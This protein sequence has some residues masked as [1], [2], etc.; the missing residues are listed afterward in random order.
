[1]AGPLRSIQAH[2]KP[3]CDPP[4][5]TIFLAFYYFSFLTVEVNTCFF[6][7]ESEGIT[8]LISS[9]GNHFYNSGW[10][11]YVAPVPMI[12]AFDLK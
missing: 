12:T 7:N 6:K 2:E 11:L 5:I 4:K 3:E 8:L 9:L 10:V 1:M